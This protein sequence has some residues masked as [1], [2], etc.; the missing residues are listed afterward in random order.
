MFPPLS[1][2]LSIFVTYPKE[3]MK[4][5]DFY[6]LKNL[7]TPG[8]RM[9]KYPKNTNT[10][11]VSG[12]GTAPFLKYSCFIGFKSRKHVGHK[13]GRSQKKKLGWANCEKKILDWVNCL[14]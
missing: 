9:Q 12:T 3:K 2:L 13:Q 14:I 1:L 6:F 7:G 11:K 4:E 5:N 8:V 10:Q